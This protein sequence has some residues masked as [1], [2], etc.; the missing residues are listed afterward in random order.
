MTYRLVLSPR[1]LSD[2][3]KLRKSG[4]LAS[5][6]KV[7]TILHELMEHPLTGTGKPEKLKFREDTYSRRLSGKDR[8]IYSIHDTTVTVDVLQILGHYDDK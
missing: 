2:L 5:Q 1:A 8:I 6:K 4:N 7:Q 3:E